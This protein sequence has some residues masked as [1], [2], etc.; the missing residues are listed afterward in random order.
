LQFAAAKVLLFCQMA[1]GYGT[2]SLLFALF[3]QKAPSVDAASKVYFTTSKAYSDSE[4]SLFGQ[5]VRTVRTRS[6]DGPD[7]L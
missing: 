7:T 5:R 6:P 4:Q 2:F 3:S 1:K